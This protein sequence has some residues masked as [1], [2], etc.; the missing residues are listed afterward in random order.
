MVFCLINLTI[1]CTTT[2]IVVKINHV[3]HILLLIHTLLSRIKSDLCSLSSRQSQ[4]M[5]I[6][7]NSVHPCLHST[8]V[9]ST[10]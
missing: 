5:Q 2:P 8:N 10:H 6:L 4:L 1:W 7:N 9:L 3:G